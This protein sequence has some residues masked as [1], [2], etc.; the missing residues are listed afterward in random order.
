MPKN[1]VY[2]VIKS[3]KRMEQLL[4][5]LIFELNTVDGNRDS[6]QGIKEA[7]LK[8]TQDERRRKNLYQYSNTHQLGII[9]HQLMYKTLL[10]YK[11][12]RVRGKISFHA[13]S[14][15]K[16]ILEHIVSKIYESYRDLVT[17]GVL[18]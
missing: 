13:F 14:K 2:L 12:M 18:K 6:A 1:D 11:I 17:Q 3:E 16:T 9:S 10:K 5:L 4:K 7:L 8:Q 15:N